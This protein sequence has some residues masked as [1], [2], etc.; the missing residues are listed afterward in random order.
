MEQT[1]GIIIRLTKLT[2]TSL[3]VH[4]CT[5]DFGLLKTVAKGARRPKSAFA[6]KLDLFYRAELSWVRSRKSELHTLHEIAV[7]DYA[8]GFRKSYSDTLVAAYFC[9]L[10]CHV[11]ETDHPLPELYD[12]LYRGLNYLGEKGANM[13]GVLH[14]E[15]E[16]VRLLGLGSD[17]HRARAALEANYGRLPP[18]RDSC[19]AFLND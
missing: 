5:R 4:W 6:G 11:A 12:L 2:E 18:S 8:E 3:I 19:L 17:K 16:M 14:Y 9:E 7:E 10:L 13:K 15:A 1:H